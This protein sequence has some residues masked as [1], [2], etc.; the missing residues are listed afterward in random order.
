MIYHILDR[1]FESLTTIDTE[2]DAGIVVENDIHTVGITNH[3]LLNQLSLDL[4]KNTGPRV[5]DYDPN[6]PYETALIKEGVYIVF[7]NDRNENVCLFIRAIESEDEETRPISAIDIGTEL[8]NGSASIFESNKAQHID[9]YVNRELFDT[10]WQ[11]GINELGTNIKRLVDTSTDETPL[12]RLQSI[13][14]A[15]DCEMTFTIEFQNLKVTKK[16]VNIY[17]KIGADKTDTVLYSGV[18]VITMQKSVDI[19]NVITA[20]EDTNHGFDS[21]GTGDGRFFTRF[22][23]SIIYDRE[24]NAL[25]GRGN[26]FEERFSGFIVGRYASSGTAQI[27]NYNELRSILEERSQPSFSAEVEMLFQDQDFEVGDWL[28]F[29]DEDYNPALHLKA[30]VLTKEINRTDQSQ[31]RLVI[32]NYQLLESLVSADLKAMQDQMNRPDTI[33]M[34]SLSADTGTAFMDGEEKIVTITARVTRNGQDISSKIV[35][36]DLLWQKVDKEGVHDAEW[37][38]TNSTAGISVTVSAADVNEISS[39]RCILTKYDNHFVQAI[40]FLNGLRDVARKVLRLTGP[41]TIVSAHISDTHYATDSIVRDD[42]ENYGRSNNHIKNVAE[43]SHMID[44]DYIVLN[45]DVHDG[46]TANKDIAKSNYK[47]AISSLS[48]ADCP[49]FISWGNHCNNSMGDGRTNSI[50][51]TYKNYKPKTPMTGLH[52]KGAAQLTNEE[53]YEIATRPSTI[54]DIVENTTDKMGYYYYDV[55]NKKVRVIILNPQ[56]IPDTLDADGYIKYSGINVAGYRQKQIDWLYQTLRNTPEDTTVAVYQHFGFG[57]RYAT[58]RAY[59]P[60]NYEII[61]GIFNS[62]VTGGTFSSSYTDNS[63]FKASISAT[64]IGRKGK[65]AF[66]AHGHFHTDRISK[67]INGIVN[68]SIGCSV[69]RPKKDQQDRPLGVLEEDLWDIVVLNTKKRHVDLIRFGKGSDR[70]FDY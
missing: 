59:L 42:L 51:K 26:T 36:E 10:G 47:E 53:M 68:Y 38:T 20:I 48:M 60:Y 22:G 7:E 11:I 35:S 40:Y 30:R 57:E 2:A 15:F 50:T 67:D 24:A 12:A 70:T 9:Y 64:F 5:N 45:G 58:G 29:I 43:L 66:L 21:L 54:F 19:D 31:N 16:M 62:F 1:Q 13:C 49:Y 39:V 33:Y 14:A 52:G 25:Y 55:P 46:G 34:L 65:L 41:D 28:T 8:R 37:E 4:K 61:D 17:F 69:S 56:D 27:D 44:L 32:G 23:E 6:A 63:D 18:D 3:T